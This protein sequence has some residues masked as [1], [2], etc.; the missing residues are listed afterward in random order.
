[1]KTNRAQKLT[2]EAVGLAIP[3]LVE[4]NLERYVVYV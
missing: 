3:A 2:S 4:R 1:M